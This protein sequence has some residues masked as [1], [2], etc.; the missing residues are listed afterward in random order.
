MTITSTITQCIARAR[1]RRWSDSNKHFGPFTFSKS[2]GSTYKP[3]GIVLDSGGGGDDDRG[4][5]HI[6]LH[7]FGY[8]L[9]A[10]LPAIVKPWKRWVDTSKYS[11]STNPRGGYWDTHPNEYGFTLSDGFLQVFLGPQTGDST[12]TKDWCTHLPW[13]E[14]RFHK[15][16]YYGPA[17]ELL[18]EWVQKG[19]RRNDF[20]E[21][22]AFQ[23][24]MPTV[25]FNF[26][27]FDDELIQCK[28][29]IERMEWKFGEG[30]F[31][32]LSLFRRSKVR[33]S[34]DLDFSKETG[35]RKGSWKGGTTGHSI[36]MLPGELHEAA[37]R[38]YCEQHDMVFS[39]VE[40]A[41]TPEGMHLS[42]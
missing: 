18:R 17:G 7:A 21:R 15:V 6:R 24:T 11:W 13:T 10:E 27:D 16:G 29:H 26:Y 28:T 36:E 39:S 14:W 42:V 1:R 9:I 40:P 3:L 4:A 34:L 31:K 2:D 12:T 37:F 38:R 23:K 30:W 35:Q 32:W 5:C 19:R 25:T 8:A 33:W 41:A 20:D 22:Y